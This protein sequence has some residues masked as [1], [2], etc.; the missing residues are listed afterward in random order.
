MGNVE[1]DIIEEV[2]KNVKKLC[3]CEKTAISITN[4]LGAYAALDK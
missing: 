1:K 2:Q 4:I 3:D